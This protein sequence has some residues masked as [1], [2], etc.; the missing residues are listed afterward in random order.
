MTEQG[1]VT[2]G[3][4]DHGGLKAGRRGAPARRPV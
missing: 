1:R 4:T 3:G 2:A